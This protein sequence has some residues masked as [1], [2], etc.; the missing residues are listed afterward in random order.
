MEHSR[1]Q[2]VELPQVLDLCEVGWIGAV[3]EIPE[4]ARAALPV[5]LS[6]TV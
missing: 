4:M 2:R 5:F 6:V 3:I 1:L